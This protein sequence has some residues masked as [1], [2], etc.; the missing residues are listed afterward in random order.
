MR[1]RAKPALTGLVRALL[2][3]YRPTVLYPTPAS[4]LQPERLYLYLDALWRRREMQGTT[5]EV[6]C[7]VGGTTAI[8]A[9]MCARTGCRR[10]YVCIDTFSGFVPSQFEHDRRR[11]RVPAL[12]ARLFDQNSLPMVRTLLERYGCEGVDLIQGDIATLPEER[13]PDQIA[14]ALLDVDLEVPVLEGLRRIVPRLAPGG[15]VLVDDC[16]VGTSWAGARPGYRRF[17]QEA[18]LPEH[19]ENGMGIIEA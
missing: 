5:L 17:V 4:S 13:L 2:R 15:I 14:V 9:R 16:V 10:P 19:Y 7:W 3:R 8:A 12:S 6:G 11:H 1:V 18:G